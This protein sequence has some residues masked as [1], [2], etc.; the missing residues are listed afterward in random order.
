MADTHPTANTA[1]N[2]ATPSDTETAKSTEETVQ[3]AATAVQVA[4]PGRGAEASVIVESGLTYKLV[5]P[6]LRF[7]Q[8]GG[9]LVVHWRDGG[10]TTLEDYLVFAQ[11]DLPPALTLADGTVISFDQLVASIEGF[12]LGAIAP[13]AGPAAAQAAGGAFNTPFD[14]GDIGEGPGITDLLLNTELQFGLIEGLEELPGVV[15]AVNAPP[16]ADDVLT[17][18][19]RGELPGDLLS[20]LSQLFVIDFDTLLA[21]GTF[22][23]DVAEPYTEDGFVFI[24]STLFGPASFNAFVTV[25]DGNADFTGSAALVVNFFGDTVTLTASG[26]GVFDL[27]SIDLAEIFGSTPSVT[28]TG[29][30]FGGGTVTQT[31][32]LDGLAGAETFIFSGDFDN[33]VSVSWDQ[34]TFTSVHQF[35]NIVIAGGGSGGGFDRSTIAFFKQLTVDGI[36]GDSDLVVADF[37]GS[38]AET[39]LAGLAF[40]LTS[41][42]NYGFLIKVTSGGDVS[43]LNVS[44]TFTS[45]DTMWWVATEADVSEFE[46]LPDATFTY[47]VTDA[48]GQSASATVVIA[49]GLTL[50]GT[51]DGEILVGGTGPDDLFGGGGDDVLSGG[52]G[53]DTFHYESIGDGDD[54]ITDF[55]DGADTIDLDDLFDALNADVAGNHDTD[56]DEGGTERTDALM[57]GVDGGGN[58]VLTINDT[59]APGDFA[60]FSITFLGL[61]LTDEAA[62]LAAIVTE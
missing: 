53:A 16:L 30:V 3:L 24:T 29:E 45:T 62:V 54:V 39:S 20:A 26:A 5:D 36:I 41:D 55:L 33:V 58:L 17:P 23:T 40:T 32:T 56:Y 52:A 31:F 37:G 59:E 51:T 61:D 12:D 49:A 7:T 28:F 57:F 35:D 10:H 1:A 50:T 15:G 44:E 13:A 47:S 11:T 42:P 46:V 22:L 6:V 21:S 27:Q 14:G 8:D 4:S 43:V 18:A 60:D 9:N 48:D 2:Q 25:D 38:D 34:G 19:D